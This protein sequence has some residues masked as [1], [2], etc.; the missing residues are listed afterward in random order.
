MDD[1]YTVK[2]L[3][4]SLIDASERENRLQSA[5]Q[6]AKEDAQEW[7]EQAMV[8]KIMFQELD[9]AFEVEEAKTNDERLARQEAD[10]RTRQYQAEVLKAKRREINANEQCDSAESEVLRLEED[11]A[12][13]RSAAVAAD[14][15]L[16]RLREDLALAER[17]ESAAYEQRDTLEA[18]VCTLRDDVGIAT[19]RMTMLERQARAFDTTLEYERLRAGKAEDALDAIAQELRST[20]I[21]LSYTLEKYSDLEAQHITSGSVEPETPFDT[22]S[23]AIDKIYDT[24]FENGDSFS[25]KHDRGLLNEIDRGM[26]ETMVHRAT[27]STWKNPPIMATEMPTFPKPARLRPALA[28]ATA[29]RTE[30]V[31]AT[32]RMFTGP[33]ADL[34]TPLW[35]WMWML[36]DN[37]CTFPFK[38]SKLRRGLQQ[39]LYES[40]RL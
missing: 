7:K 18:K 40:G 30:V 32:G 15:H 35:K 10:E 6:T 28:S 14:L 36:R 17:N 1:L 2:F 38:G 26:A 3:H 9:D 39:G 4:Q 33:R 23:V 20:K 13:E 22:G 8:S 27:L 5:L 21:K 25:S 19:D 37:H 29:C 31:K 12:A 24:K 34:K 16:C 11:L